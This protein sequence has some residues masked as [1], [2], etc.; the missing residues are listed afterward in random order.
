M[1]AYTKPQQNEEN[2]RLG[3]RKVR[4]TLLILDLK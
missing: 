3:E 4:S 1:V 2:E